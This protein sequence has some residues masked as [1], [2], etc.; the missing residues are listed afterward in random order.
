M[1]NDD[2]FMENFARE[3]EL[4]RNLQKQSTDAL[5]RAEDRFERMRNGESKEQ[6]FGNT[7]PK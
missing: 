1:P 4:L 3:I 7:P 5:R 2:D 6:V